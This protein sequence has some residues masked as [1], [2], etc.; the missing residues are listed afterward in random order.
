MYEPTSQGNV[1]MLYRTYGQVCTCSVLCI[2]E[3][4]T[5]TYTLCI[6]GLTLPLRDTMP[7]TINIQ[8]L[9][10]F[11]LPPWCK[12]DRRSSWMLRRVYLA[13]RPETSVNNCKCKL[14]NIRMSEN[15]GSYLV[16]IATEKSDSKSQNMIPP[17]PHH[18]WHQI[19]T[20]TMQPLQLLH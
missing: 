2:K 19:K 18:P 8:Y 11:R 12:W 13:G 17:N 4:F 14:R 6:S 1:A 9:R 16:Y 10:D 20:A 7:H 15:L 3:S 5:F